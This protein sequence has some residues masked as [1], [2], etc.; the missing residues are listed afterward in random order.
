MRGLC[1]IC[2]VAN[3]DV[4]ITDGKILCQQCYQRFEKGKTET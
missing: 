4:I 3:V 1:H 2:M